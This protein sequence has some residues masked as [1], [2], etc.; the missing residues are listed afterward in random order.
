MEKNYIE[1][2]TNLEREKVKYVPKRLFDQLIDDYRAE[3]SFEG[4]EEDEQFDK[5]IY[6]LEQKAEKESRELFV[7]EEP[8]KK[9]DLETCRYCGGWM[10]PEFTDRGWSTTYSRRPIAE[11]VHFRC[12]YCGATSP[13]TVLR[14]SLLDNEAIKKD[15]LRGIETAKREVKEEEEGNYEE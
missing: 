14:V 13:T 3:H 9:N 4:P 10:T 7:L 12:A 6:E 5:D 11:L 8:E 15:I 2:V 1:K